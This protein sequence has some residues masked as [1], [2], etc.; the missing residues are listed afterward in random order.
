MVT[1]QKI[2]KKYKRFDEAQKLK[3]EQ[4][5]QG[6]SAPQSLVADAA[7]NSSL[8]F[9]QAEKLALRKMTLN[10]ADIIINPFTYSLDKQDN[11]SMMVDQAEVADFKK[12]SKYRS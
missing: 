10:A 9:T 4:L 2:I 1:V 7:I 11:S 12:Q 6:T 3:S 5:G 8:E